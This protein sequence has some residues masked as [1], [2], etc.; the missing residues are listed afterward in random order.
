MPRLDCTVVIRWLAVRHGESTWN[1]AG[2]IQ[3]QRSGVP[4][5][6]RGRAQA[7]AAASSLVGEGIGRIISSDL[8]RARETAAIIAAA[9][10][11]PVALA[12]ALREQALGELEGRLGSALRAE[13][14]PDGADISEIRWG[15]GE[16]VAD[17][18]ARLRAFVAALEQETGGGTILLVTHEGT[19]Q[20]LQAVLAGRGHRDVV[21]E[22]IGHGEVIE[23]SRPS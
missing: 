17:V 2:R 20:V 12:P 1:V 9:L 19:L 6:A 5:T 3:G 23:L 16:S 15:G 8:L 22:P 18:H 7:R 14:V 4:L 21:W 10:G 11:L 13:P